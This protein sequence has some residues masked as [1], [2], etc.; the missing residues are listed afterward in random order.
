MDGHRAARHG[1]ERVAGFGGGVGQVGEDVCEKK[2]LG[3]CRSTAAYAV[4][5]LQL[6]TRA[7]VQAHKR[8]DLQARA[9]PHAVAEA[10]HSSD[11]GGGVQGGAEQQ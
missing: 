4:P 7:S 10:A 3:G 5:P 6:Y 1:G 9:C 8:A 11:C 2:A